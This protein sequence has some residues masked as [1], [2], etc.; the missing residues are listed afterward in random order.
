MFRRLMAEATEAIAQNVSD[1]HFSHAIV[2]GK[3]AYF[4]PQVTQVIVSAN[5]RG[6]KKRIRGDNAERLWLVHRSYLSLKWA[7]PLCQTLSI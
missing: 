3:A 1:R 2:C 4:A 6:S 7:C 5:V